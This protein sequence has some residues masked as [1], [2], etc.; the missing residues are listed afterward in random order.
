MERTEDI[1]LNPDPAA[2]ADRSY[3]DWPAVLAG[4][5]VATA[6]AALFAAF[7]GGLGLSTISAEPG[8]GSFNFAIILSAIWTVATIVASYMAGGYIAGRMRRRAER[9]TSDEVTVRDGINGLVVWGLGTIVG[10]LLIANTIAATASAVGSAATAAGSAVGS[11][12]EAAGTAAG[13]ALQ[14]SGVNAQAGA[15]LNPVE[16]LNDTLLRP[17][18]VDPLNADRSAV[19]AQTASILANVMA[20]GEISDPERQYLVSATQAQTNLSAAE[21]NA[22][23]DQAVKATQDAKAEVDRV[24]QEAKDLAIKAA[25]TA[26]ISAVLTGFMLAAAGLVAAAAAYIGAVR[27]G[28]HRDEGRVFGGF[29]YRG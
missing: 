24:A 9:A 23:V 6:I 5:V 18:T 1:T 15:A 17:S 25:E 20:T 27:G 4:A 2:L 8:E 11:A 19:A 16:Y 26:R 29:A 22:R 3:V 12:I 7:G 14:S 28:R 13:G 21:A 10:A